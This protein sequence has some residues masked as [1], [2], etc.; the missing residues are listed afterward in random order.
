MRNYLETQ[1][2]LLLN[3]CNLS[4]NL[5]QAQG[6]VNRIIK[7]SIQRF[8]EACAVP[9][10][11]CYGKHT[12]M[13]MSD[14]IYVMKNVRYIIDASHSGQEESG[15]CIIREDQIRERKIDGILISSFKYR[16]EIKQNLVQN[17]PEICYLDIYEELEKNKIFLSFEYFSQQH[18]YGYYSSINTW[19]R[20]LLTAQTD[21]ERENLYRNLVS[22]YILIKD[23]RSAICCMEQARDEIGTALFQKLLA[24]T[25]DMYRIE[26]EAA[27]AIP[28]NNVV[29]LCMDGMREKDLTGNQ[30]PGMKEWIVRKGRFY[31]NAYSVSTSTNESLIPAYSEND[32][33]RTKYYEKITIAEADC[34]FISE[35][36]RQKRTIHFYTDGI[37]YVDSEYINVTDKMQTVTE[38]LW[39][40][41]LDAVDE[42]NGLFYVHVL[43]ESHF[44]YP[45][46]YTEEPLV[47]D[48]TS[49]M[50]DYLAVNGQK[51]RTDYDRQHTDALRYLDDV[52]TPLIGRLK[53][54]MV[55]FAD[56]GNILLSP[57]ESI[58][59]V[60]RTKF[61]FHS[62]LVRV[63][64]VIKSPETGEGQ[65]DEL[66][67]IMSLNTILTDLMCHKPAIPKEREYVKLVRSEIYNPDFKY[68]YHKCGY[69]QELLA[70]EVFVFADGMK[71]AIYSDGKSELFSAEDDQKI[72]DDRKKNALLKKV[73]QKITVCDF[74]Q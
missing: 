58:Q 30:M 66:V 10:I 56:H 51:L 39:D 41:I 65:T 40:F 9:A 60:E 21:E 6:N 17:Y 71:L 15:F 42:E 61:S 45:N 24:M 4:S 47:A 53:C 73:K 48:G 7:E 20:K 68:I 1:Y 31:T 64:L 22:E 37:R 59:E 70:F 50:F 72:R 44:S 55:L 74:L 13:L 63:P 52:L 2:K 25:K 32:D 67:S 19:K 43:Y 69:D 57:E 35:A 11:W 5:A 3:A 28:E 46:P 49:I 26:Q 36:V 8:T 12:K 38:K 14:F 23:F 27:G 33:L 54:R 29:M 18:P 34:R 62:D 16:N